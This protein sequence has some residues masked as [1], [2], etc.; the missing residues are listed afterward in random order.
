MLNF[1]FGQVHILI[2]NKGIE[3]VPVIVDSSTISDVINF[4]GDDYI[5][6]ESNTNYKYEKIGLTFRIA[7]YDKNQ[8]I[9]SIIIE[10]PFQA[11]T[12]NGIVL[13]E[14]TMNDVSENFGKSGYGISENYAYRREKGIYFY[15]KKDA[16]QKGFNLEEKIYK[17]EINNN[18]ESGISSRVNFEFNHQPR[19]EKISELLTILKRE[20]IDTVELNLFWEKEEKAKENPYRLRKMRGFKREIENSLVQEYIELCVAAHFYFLNII[21]SERNIIYLKL[22]DESDSLLFERNDKSDY[23]DVDF[24]VYIYGTFCGIA[25][26]P[27]KKCGEMLNLVKENNYNQLAEWVKSINPELATYGYIGL[28]FLKR[29]GIKLQPIE[30]KRMKELEKL[31]I[32]LSA[33]EGCIHGITKKMNEVLNKYNL[34]QIYLSFKQYGRLK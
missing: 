7:A 27:P 16:E 14:S 4:L 30:L 32:A 21:K 9:R 17:I 3:G 19:E 1:A 11:K 5:K 24:D 22:T 15:V 6:N 29:K 28:H 31:D 20:I 13:N 8:I 18:N 23:L 34:E 33:C 2:P 12:K 10:A 26:T 25:G